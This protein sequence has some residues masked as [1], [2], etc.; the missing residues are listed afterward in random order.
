M[1]RLA[2]QGYTLA[3]VC[4]FKKCIHCGQKPRKL[5]VV[6]SFEEWGWF[7]EGWEVT[8]YFIFSYIT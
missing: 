3:R 6:L 8:L 5:L 4:Y 7:G 2:R 1:C